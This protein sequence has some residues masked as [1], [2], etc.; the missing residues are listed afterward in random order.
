MAPNGY[1]VHVV[2]D[3]PSFRS[4]VTRLLAAGGFAVEAFESAAAF[5]DRAH[6]APGCLLLDVDMPG[7]T[8]L[9]LYRELMRLNQ[10]MPVVFVTGKADAQVRAAVAR[11]GAVD[12]L[13]KPVRAAELFAAV[14]RALQVCA[15]ER[16]TA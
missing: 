15:G 13:T 11:A 1:L 8:G 5:L 9:E 2:D 7:M 6:R 3:D 16:Q 12:F 4:S 14:N 10:A